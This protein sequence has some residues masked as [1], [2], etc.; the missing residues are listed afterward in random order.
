MLTFE[1]SSTNS[2][3]LLVYGNEINP[4]GENREIVRDFL[5][6]KNSSPVRRGTHDFW[7]TFVFGSTVGP[8]HWCEDMSILSPDRPLRGIVHMAD[9]PDNLTNNDLVSTLILLFKSMVTTGW[10]RILF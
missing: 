5:Y 8:S 6:G 7:V 3:I 9:I 2:N 10:Y 1:R 4:R